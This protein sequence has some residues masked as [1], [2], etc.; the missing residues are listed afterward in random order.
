MAAS[1]DPIHHQRLVQGAR[2]RTLPLNV[3]CQA[4]CAFCYER[5]LTDLFPHLTTE[6]IPVYDQERF[7]EFRRL[8]AQAC[9]WEQESGQPPV[10][11]ILPQFERNARGISHFPFSDTFSAGL[12]H[13]QI[14]EL[15]QM[16][17]GDICLLYTV[18]LNMDPDFI[19]YLTRKYPDTFKLYLSIVTFDREIRRR[20]LHPRI[21]VDELRQVCRL[22]KQA[23]FFL[24][25]FD[26]Q[27]ISAD[28]DELLSTTS[29]ENGELFIHKLYYNR[30]SPQRVVQYAKLAEQNREAAVRAIAR[31]DY[32]QRTVMCSLGA[33][34]QA[35]TR[36]NEIYR[37]LNPCTGRA[38]EVVFCAPGARRVITQFLAGKGPSVV[39]PL[40]SAFGG[41]VD[42]VQ[43]GTARDVVQQLADLKAAG[44]PV[45][46]IFLPDA[47]FFIDGGYDI[48]GDRVE[49]IR[50]AFPELEVQL[51]P[52][53]K[54]V[55]NSVV[56]LAD[57]VSYYAAKGGA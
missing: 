24:I 53:P 15:V 8:H 40:T 38:D 9:Q 25:L 31:S 23:I 56:S 12:T 41:N 54:P 22:T 16:R 36:R 1:H 18:G 46:R 45:G 14:E 29:P 4:R 34:I 44:K 20:L 33:D 28:V 2:F 57:C 42:L 10:F 49:L 19:G 51:L 55:I 37:L 6:Y 3:Q 26:E 21:D 48:Y 39:L 5:A 50:N 7:D 32:S 47:M 13:E 35:Y 43:G 30:C 52:I 11:R 27:Q 17:E